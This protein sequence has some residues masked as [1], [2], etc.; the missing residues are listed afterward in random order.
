[1][2]RPMSTAMSIAIAQNQVYP[3]VLVEAT[4]QSGPVY[5]WSGY[6][7]LVYGGN[8]YIG[9]GA[10]GSISPIEEGSTVE[11]KG[12]VL[13]F[14]GFDASLLPSV[15][16]EFLLRKPAIVS[17][18]LFNEGSLIA[19]PLICFQGLMDRPQIDATGKV[20]TITINCESELLDMSVSV[21]RRYD[22]EDQA[23]DW[24]GD[25][26]MNFVV[27]I[28]EITIWFGEAPASSANI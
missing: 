17:L 6:G 10:M 26:G 16:T 25:L 23:R 9:V 15:M 13:T 22:Q 4:F 11:A 7:T 20:A 5:L 14:S 1:M 24:P 8:S 12:V 28:Q 3:C 19:N 27:N 18:G 2:P 21:E